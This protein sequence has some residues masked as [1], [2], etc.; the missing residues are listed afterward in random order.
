MKLQKY[1]FLHHVALSDLLSAVFFF[2]SSWVPKV[3]FFTKAKRNDPKEQGHGVSKKVLED[4]ECFCRKATWKSE[5]GNIETEK[6]QPSPFF[7][8][9]SS[10]FPNNMRNITLHASLWGSCLLLPMPFFAAV[11]PY[12]WHSTFPLRPSALIQLTSHCEG[13]ALHICICMQIDLLT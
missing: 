7:F 2:F 1:Q 11:E 6:S 8:P 10:A 4:D 5:N 3:F 12:C 13:S 9:D